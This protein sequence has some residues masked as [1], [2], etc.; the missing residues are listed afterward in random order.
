MIYIV[1]LLSITTVVST[2]LLLM[3]KKEIANIRS[4]LKKIREDRS[5][6]KLHS[7]TGTAE[8]DA[9]I[10]EINSLLE[11]LRAESMLY[12]RRRH[13]LDNMLTNISHDLRTP[14]TSALGYLEIV[15]EG[16]ISEE[17]EERELAVISE[18]LGRLRELIDSFFEFSRI[19]S[20]DKEPSKE[21]INL[22]ALI[23]D[24]VSGFYDVYEDSGRH[25]ELDLKE[26]R[27]DIVSNR[28][29]LL[30]IVDNLISN[31]YKHGSGDLRIVKE[32]NKLIFGN[33]MPEGELTDVSRVF[34]EFWTTDVSRTKGSTGLGLAIV[35]QFSEM[36]NI[37]ISAD[38][39][40]G[41][42]RIVLDLAGIRA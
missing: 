37:G 12:R 11:D 28:M 42:F 27:F 16:G 29:M 40:D 14:L 4:S 8:T 39:E 35:K 41:S 6:E 3:Q 22:V 23:E 9:L 32:D 5:S 33:E 38:A 31:S 21:T 25:I 13:E 24:S 1:I 2:V 20:E 34:D 30:R 26:T 15:R 19:V 18:R 7:V 17:E 36:L 10:T